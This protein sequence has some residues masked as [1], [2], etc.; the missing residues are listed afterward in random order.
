MK[1]NF[2]KD[3]QKQLIIMNVPKIPWL[4]SKITLT[5]RYVVCVHVVWGGVG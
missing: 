3:S 2:F 5:L 1:W 4:G